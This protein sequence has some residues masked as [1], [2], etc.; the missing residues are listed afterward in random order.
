MVRSYWY[1]REA[2]SNRNRKTASTWCVCTGACMMLVLTERLLP[3]GVSVLVLKGMTVS[4]RYVCTGAC[5]M[6]VLTER[7][8]PLGV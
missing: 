5:V 6:L 7:L 2:C 8:L 4:T 1:L 3:L